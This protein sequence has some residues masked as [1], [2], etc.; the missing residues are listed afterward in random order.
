MASPVAPF[1]PAPRGAPASLFRYGLAVAITVVAILSQYVVPTWLPASIVVYGNLPGD[2]LVVYGLPIVAFATLVGGAP[3]RDWSSRMRLAAAEGFGWFGALSLLALLVL[4]AL[5]L[6]YLAVDPSA[7]GLLNRPNP[8]LEAA[9]GNPWF[10]VGFSFVI[11]AFEETIFR[12]WIFGYW[13]DR[14]GSWVGPAVWTSALFALVHLYYATTYLAAAPLLFPTLFLLGLSFAATYRYS[15]GNLVV[16]AALHG[17]QDALA[18][19]T[20]VPAGFASLAVPVHYLLILGGALLFLLRF[21]RRRASLGPPLGAIA[22]GP[23]TAP[24]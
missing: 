12:G 22:A 24:P 14:P 17:A 21:V 6:I 9:R 10:Y 23:P 2:L 11:G 5:V 8:A 13:R 15:G 20:L 1:S 4:V 16:P 18:F 3:L 7:L 19:L